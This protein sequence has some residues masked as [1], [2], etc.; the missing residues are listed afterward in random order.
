[1]L[2]TLS[3]RDIVLIEHL[4]LEFGS[5]LGALTGETG[6]G[7]SI[8]LDA[9]SL[10]IGARADIELIRQG[11]DR[12]LVIAEFELSDVS[13][14]N[15]ILAEYGIKVVENF[16]LRR[17]VSKDG[18]SRAFIDD[19]P[20]SVTLLRQIGALLVEIHGQFE[21]HGLNEVVVEEAASSWWSLRPWE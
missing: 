19:Q 9:L 20:V 2:R 8:L 4:D 10:A 6:S 16:F 12:G 18:R 5:G 15:G 7:K 13:I 3:I 14:I 21:T 17:V 1:M 11:A